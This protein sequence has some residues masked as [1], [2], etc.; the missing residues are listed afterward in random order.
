MLRRPP[1]STRTD[2]LFPYTTLVRSPVLIRDRDYV[3]RYELTAEQTIRQPRFAT[4]LKTLRGVEIGGL[5]FGEEVTGCQAVRA[6]HTAHGSF[7]FRFLLN[8]GQY[9]INNGL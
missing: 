5:G 1:R 2:T 3:I 6:G 9:T 7:G 8:I 4:L